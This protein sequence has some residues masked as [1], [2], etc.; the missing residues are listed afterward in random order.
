MITKNPIF[1]TYTFGQINTCMET[2]DRLSLSLCTTKGGTIVSLCNP[3]STCSYF[4]ETG[5]FTYKHVAEV[6]TLN[7][8]LAML[9]K[10]S[11]MHLQKP[12]FA[13]GN[14]QMLCFRI[15][16]SVHITVHL[17]LHTLIFPLCIATKVDQ[18][19]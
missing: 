11:G 9:A 13:C 18:S 4:G 8:M 16:N 15:V 3:P 6:H 14:E 17:Q 5:P 2:S 1:D 12:F 7:G 19:I 10:A